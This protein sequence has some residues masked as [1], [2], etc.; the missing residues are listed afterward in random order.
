[1]ELQSMAASTEIL[2]HNVKTVPR[3]FKRVQPQDNYAWSWST[4]VK[5]LWNR[6]RR[7]MPMTA[8]S[9]GTS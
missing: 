2:N 8:C 9:A 1:V 7:G 4:T 5:P 6:T 3:L